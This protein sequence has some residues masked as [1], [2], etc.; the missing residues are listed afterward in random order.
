MGFEKLRR[1]ARRP[2]SRADVRARGGAKR[3]VSFASPQAKW[4]RRVDSCFASPRRRRH[5]HLTPTGQGTRLLRR[6]GRLQP[7]PGLRGRGAPASPSRLLPLGRRVDASEAALARCWLA[8]GPLV[9][10]D[11]MGDVGGP[12]FG[13]VGRRSL[14]GPPAAELPPSPWDHEAGP[15]SSSAPGA[16]RRRGSSP[17]TR[18]GG[19]APAAA[20]ARRRPPSSGARRRGGWRWR[21]GFGGGG[22]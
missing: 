8:G 4:R 22:G 20:A 14:A 9:G 21:G 3:N 2:S 19:G 17:S 11:S 6:Q 18:A 13:R 16:E 15:S 5:Q 1:V 12:V 10:P 7:L